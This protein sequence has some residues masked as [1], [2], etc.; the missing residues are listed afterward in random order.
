MIENWASSIACSSPRGPLHFLPALFF[1]FFGENSNY[2]LY[3]FGLM[4]MLTEVLRST[5]Q[6]P[7]FS[8]SSSPER[9]LRLKGHLISKGYMYPPSLI[10]VGLTLLILY[11]ADLQV[12]IQLAVKILLINLCIWA[13]IIFVIR[14]NY[15]SAI[16]A[17][18]KKGYSA[19][20]TFISTTSKRSIS[21]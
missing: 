15:L 19:A 8:S 16:H 9:K 12:N 7:V 20:K 17:S 6:E 11:N 14:K 5:M 2:N 1:F 10:I 13:A 18:I 4:A 21:S 3:I